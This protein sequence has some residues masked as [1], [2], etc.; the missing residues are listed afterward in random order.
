[1]FRKEK[2]NPWPWAIVAGLCLVV[3][4]NGFVFILGQQRPFE[5][6]TDNYYQKALQYETI[7]EARNTAARNGWKF[8]L[9]TACKNEETQ[10]SVRISGRDGRN[11]SGLHGAVAL[12]RP[13]DSKLDRQV[14]LVENRAVLYL[15]EFVKL[16]TGP[17]ELTFIFK[18]TTNQVVFYQKLPFVGL[19]RQ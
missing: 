2:F 15:S 4:V 12:F 7:I 8:Q 5:L 6:V 11:I 9:S 14:D 19:N 3:A 10:L 16:R 1:M 17:W 18:D 13:S